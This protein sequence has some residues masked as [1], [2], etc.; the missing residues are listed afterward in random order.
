MIA[1]FIQART[2]SSRFPGKVLKPILGKPMLELE[3]E[4]VKACRLVDRV[5]V[6][7]STCPEDQQIADLGRKIGADV[8]CGSLDNVLDR[9]YQAA[10]KFKPEH[11]VRLTGDCPLIDPEVVDRMIGIYQAQACDYGTNCM[12]P[13]YP[14]GLDAEIFSFKALKEAHEEAVLPSHLEH[15][16]LFFEGQPKRFKIANLA[17][18]R[19]LSKMR[20][21]VDEPQDFEFVKSIYEALY[22]LKP[23]FSM[24]D[25]LGLLKERPELLLLN[26]DFMRNEGLIKSQRKDKAFLDQKGK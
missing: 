7:T 4:R 25:I 1:A 16:S 5:V 15:I 20:W 24:Q 10:I 26:Q 18:D 21:T 23:C 13:T 12:P 8:F 17:C 11:I 14:D 3:I 19:D 22:A 2:S 6:V 9:F